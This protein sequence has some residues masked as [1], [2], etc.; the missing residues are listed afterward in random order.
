[1]PAD[2]QV[3]IIVYDLLNGNLV[4]PFAVGVKARQQKRE[5][6]KNQERKRPSLNNSLFHFWLSENGGKY[7]SS[8]QKFSIR[9]IA[10][11]D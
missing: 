10:S 3:S 1:M 7:I 11:G 4:W 2:V 6:V 9:C 5:C 8:L